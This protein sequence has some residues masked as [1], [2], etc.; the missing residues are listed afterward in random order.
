MFQLESAKV[1]GDIISAA[2]IL[3]NLGVLVLIF[4]SADFAGRAMNEGRLSNLIDELVLAEG[5]DKVAF[6]KAWETLMEEANSTE[7]MVRAKIQALDDTMFSHD[8]V[9]QTKKVTSLST[10]HGM[11]VEH[12]PKVEKALKKM[13]ESFGAEFHE[14]RVKLK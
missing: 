12:K 13:A 8:H 11:A 10:L 5:D 7:E 6:I 2:L 1:D 9:K 4:V 3:T 14:G